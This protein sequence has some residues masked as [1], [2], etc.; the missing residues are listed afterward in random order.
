M[1][2]T[3]YLR[4]LD[5]DNV[6]HAVVLGLGEN[7]ESVTLAGPV[8]VAVYG[9]LRW[10]WLTVPDDKGALTVAWLDA[11]GEV[12][13][14]SPVLALA[15]GHVGPTTGAWLIPPGSMLVVESGAGPGGE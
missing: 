10:T 7:R 15:T 14:E 5:A 8:P 9:R 4:V 3:A 1:S 6:T 13:E 11:A 12:V 2:K